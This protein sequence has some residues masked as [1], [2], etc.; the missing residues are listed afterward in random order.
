MSVAWW[1]AEWT[2][3]HCASVVWLAAGLV[4]EVTVT[5]MML[6]LLTKSAFED[7]VEGKQITGVLSMCSWAMQKRQLLCF[8]SPYGLCNCEAPVQLK[9]HLYLQMQWIL[10]QNFLLDRCFWLTLYEVPNKTTE[11]KSCFSSLVIKVFKAASIIC[12]L[13]NGLPSPNAPIPFFSLPMTDN[14]TVRWGNG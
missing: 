12:T 2:S 5:G 4:G 10:D 1:L 6:I 9:P 14:L 7:T 11:A 13:R 8:T 3:V